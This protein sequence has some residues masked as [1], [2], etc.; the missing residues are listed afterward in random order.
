MSTTSVVYVNDVKQTSGTLVAMVGSDIRGYNSAFPGPPFGPY[1]GSMM[2][3]CMLHSNDDGEDFT[4]KFIED[5]GAE[6]DVVIS[7]DGASW[8]GKFVSNDNAGNAIAPLVLKSVPTVWRTAA[9]AASRPHRQ[10]FGSVST[11]FGPST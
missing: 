2:F 1:A 6:H 10:P 7:E 11:P 5:S 8:D 9:C 3:L 4:F